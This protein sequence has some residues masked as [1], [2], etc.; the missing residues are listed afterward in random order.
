MDFSLSEE[1]ILI[2]DMARQFS[3]IELAPYAQEWDETKKMSRT[4]LEKA[5]SLGFAGIYTP[6]KSD[7]LPDAM[8]A[9]ELNGATEILAAL[10]ADGGE[11]ALK[12]AHILSPLAVCV[13]LEALN[14][15]A[16]MSFREAMN[17]EIGLS[18]AFLGTQDFFEGVR[19]ALIDK[20][21]NPKWTI[22]T[23]AGVRPLDIERRFIPTN[24]PLKFLN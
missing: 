16:E 7:F 19:A 3:D 8:Q 1:Q 22:G 13:T 2:Q 4:V 14:R 17:Q 10:K 18:L 15:G 5:A 12:Q 23:I 24:I 21:R 11:W 20:D 6:P 9:F